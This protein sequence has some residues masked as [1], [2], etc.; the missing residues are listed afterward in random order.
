ML[1]STYARECSI[2]EHESYA[3]MCMLG[4][5]G[6]DGVGRQSAE[7]SDPARGLIGV[8]RIPAR[9]EDACLAASRSCVS[10]LR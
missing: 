9:F 6:S 4:T 2:A 3:M 8:W 5:N 7:P 1:V 10:F